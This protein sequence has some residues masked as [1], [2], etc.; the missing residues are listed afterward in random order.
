MEQ[1]IL[2]ASAALAWLL[3]EDNH[4]PQL[5]PLLRDHNLVA[6]CLWRLEV[7][8]SILVKERRK[9]ITAAQGEAYLG[10]LLSLDVEIIGEPANRSITELAKTARPYQL[11]SYDAVYFDLALKSGLPLITRDSNLQNAAER[12][13]VQVMS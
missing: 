13:G 10:H 12:A 3:N 4:G 9:L 6:P 11:S 7:T 2:D 1:A 5:L 8:N